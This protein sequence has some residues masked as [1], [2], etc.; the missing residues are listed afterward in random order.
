[1]NSKIST[2]W[3]V[4]GSEL[5]VRVIAPYEIQTNSGELI[6]LEAWL[7]DFGS[8]T[9]AIALSSG[10]RGLRRKLVGRWCSILGK[11]YETYARAPFIETLDDWG[12]Y[13]P[14]GAAPSWFTGVR[15]A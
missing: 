12:W 1:V 10:S 7:P 9:G 14:S 11:S 6:V 4:A 3:R 2:A 13:G 8:P 5:G 15:Y